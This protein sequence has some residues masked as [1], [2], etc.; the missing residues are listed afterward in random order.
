[1]HPPSEQ[2][3]I[4]LKEANLEAVFEENEGL[5][6]TLEDVKELRDFYR[7]GVQKKAKAE[8]KFQEK[9]FPEA[10]DLYRDSN[11]FFSMLI[12]Q[13]F[14]TDSAEYTLFEGTQI[15]FFPNLL[16]AD[17]HL[18]M[19]LILREMG[20]EGPDQRHWKQ[21]LTFAEK[22][23]NS[24]LTEWGLKLRQQLISLLAAAQK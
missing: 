14:A 16:V 9:S 5:E 20:R 3:L 11:Q 22:S 10:L 15:L 8:N 12:L 24:E 1:M 7:G 4:P 19:G 17:N 6:V 13:H 18:K 2:R 23:L 21:G